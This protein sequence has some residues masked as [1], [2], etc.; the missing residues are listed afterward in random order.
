MHVAKRHSRDNVP[1]FEQLFQAKVIHE[2][3]LVDAE[4]DFWMHV[5]VF[6]EMLTR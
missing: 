1:Y 5:M 3:F 2:A 4:K 6:D